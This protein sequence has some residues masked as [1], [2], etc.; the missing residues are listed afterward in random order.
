MRGSNGCPVGMLISIVTIKQIWLTV[1]EKDQLFFFGRVGGGAGGCLSEIQVYF[2]YIILYYIALIQ[3]TPLLS[4]AADLSTDIKS[5]WERP[6]YC[7]LRKHAN[8]QSTAN[9]TT[10]Q[11]KT[12]EEVAKVLDAG[13]LCFLS[14]CMTYCDH[15]L[16]FMLRYGM[17][18]VTQS[19]RISCDVF[20]FSYDGNGGV[21]CHSLPLI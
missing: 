4:T 5:G 6:A 19:D 3:R 12:T 10:I 13:W 16:V 8:M 11:G 9:N 7:N 15:W 1:L 14:W 2:E 17:C 20:F 18:P 21:V